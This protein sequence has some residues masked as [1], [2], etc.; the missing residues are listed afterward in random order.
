MQP[1]SSISTGSKKKVLAV[2][3]AVLFLV[4]FLLIGL[5]VW[6]RDRVKAAW[7]VLRD[8][9]QA[10]QIETD[11]IVN[12]V[13]RLI[14][15]P[16]ATPTVAT[17]TDTEKLASQPFFKQAKNGDKVL[18][19]VEARKAYLY[20]PSTH[21]LIEAGP[22]NVAAD[23]ATSDAS[24]APQTSNLEFTVA[25]YNGTATAGLTSQYET[26]LSSIY[27]EATVTTKQNATKNDY[28]NSF[29]VDVQGNQT[30]LA[31]TL[32]QALQIPIQAL[33]EGE[34]APAAQLL[35][36]LGSDAIN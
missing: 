10:A 25:L 22:L 24:P 15:L 32:S 35:I 2:C 3:L 33:P 28:A 21:K 36:I 30:E 31:K 20:R 29:I 26:A 1:T 16:T 18:I 7:M 6:K 14:E 9:N 34:V 4:L 27:P 11:K 19:Y 12:E 23:Q 8:P 5:L 17:V 13:G